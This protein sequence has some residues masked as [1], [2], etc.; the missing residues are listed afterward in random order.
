[1]SDHFLLRC[2]C[3]A[4]KAKKER[5]RPERKLRFKYLAE[6]TRP[7]PDHLNFTTCNADLELF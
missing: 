1:M 6:W 5:R 2:L 7:H 3:A 4:G